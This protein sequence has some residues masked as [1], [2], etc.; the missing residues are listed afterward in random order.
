MVYARRAKP[1]GIYSHK[2]KGEGLLY[3]SP[4]GQFEYPVTSLRLRLMAVLECLEKDIL[5]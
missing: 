2:P 5:E 3:I 4:I 1:E